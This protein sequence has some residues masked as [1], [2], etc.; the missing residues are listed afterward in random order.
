[1][2]KSWVLTISLLVILLVLS[3]APKP[4][5]T[6]SQTSSGGI[7]IEV[8]AKTRMED[9]EF[10][11]YIIRVNDIPCIVFDSGYGL[12]CDCDFTKELQ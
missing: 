1:M 6:P 10:D 5:E 3:C 9:N 8:L 11:I 7:R 4:K 12:A 2:K